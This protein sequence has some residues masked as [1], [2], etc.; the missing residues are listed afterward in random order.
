MQLSVWSH[1]KGYPAERLVVCINVKVN[2]RV[3]V[4]G[5]GAAAVHPG[6]REGEGAQL[7]PVR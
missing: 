3:L 4:G 7:Y 1:L 2:R 6:R 5:G